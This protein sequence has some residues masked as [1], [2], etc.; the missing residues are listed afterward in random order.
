MQ[1]LLYQRNAQIHIRSYTLCNNIILQS[2]LKEHVKVRRTS[3]KEFVDEVTQE[4]HTGYELTIL[5]LCHMYNM[6]VVVLHAEYVW[7]SS[8]SVNLATCPIVL[9]MNNKGNFVGTKYKEPAI[10]PPIFPG[11][12]TDELLAIL[13]KFED[14][15]QDE[16]ERRENEELW[17]N[18]RMTKRIDKVHRKQAKDTKQLSKSESSLD[19]SVATDKSR[20]TRKNSSVSQ[21]DEE[22]ATNDSTL[23]A[24]S[25]IFRTTH[26]ANDSR[27]SS[28]VEKESPERRRSPRYS[29]K[30][31]APV[32]KKDTTE[33]RR[34]APFPPNMDKE[35]EKYNSTQDSVPDKNSE[36]LETERFSQRRTSN[37]VPRKSRESSSDNSKE[38]SSSAKSSQE[39]KHSE[40]P[41]RRRSSQFPPNLSKQSRNATCEENDPN[42]NNADLLGSLQNDSAASRRKS[43]A[44]RPSVPEYQHVDD[45][46]SDELNSTLDQYSGKR[47]RSNDTQNVTL[48]G[49]SDNDESVPKRRKT[50]D[51]VR[52]EVPDNDSD[53]SSP[54]KRKRGR[55]VKNSQNTDSDTQSGGPSQTSTPK[56]LT[57][58]NSVVI[59]NNTV[60]LNYSSGEDINVLSPIKTEENKNLPIN[61]KGSSD[62]SKKRSVEDEKKFEIDNVYCFKCEKKFLNNYALTE[63]MKKCLQ[64]DMFVCEVF[65]CVRQYPEQSLLEQHMEKDHRGQRYYCDVKGCTQKKGYLNMKSLRYHKETE[66][67]N[68][69]AKFTCDKCGKG[70]NHRGAFNTHILRHGDNKPFQCGICKVKSFYTGS[71]LKSHIESCGKPNQ[72]I[73]NVCGISYKKD[74]YLQDHMES[75]HTIKTDADSK[76]VCNRC[77]A[78]YSYKSGLYKHWQNKHNEQNKNGNS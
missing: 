44:G 77:G 76:F 24:G 1:E 18:Y 36:V 46:M 69:P 42:G 43:A 71:E 3:L 12:D 65:G 9:I 37:V 45:D 23:S 35:S 54:Q 11:D 78:K 40:V 41:E 60:P 49:H 20:S 31:N 64:S 38:I 22:R 56:R 33:R 73:C 75:K 62:K 29:G 53:H 58:R 17:K 26:N 66:H 8:P 55:P 68:G 51:N 47:K 2:L 39:P 61:N 5:T 10:L 16:K 70:F 19:D 67:S 63:H 27:E 14:K 57:R 21:T 13:L 59:G 50:L 30:E 4:K 7:A 28:K 34:S 74:K 25:P 48:A 15:L 32:E 52:D 72:F 6:S